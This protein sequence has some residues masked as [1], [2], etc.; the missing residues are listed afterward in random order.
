[1]I[2]RKVFSERVFRVRNVFAMNCS[3]TPTPRCSAA[4][5]L[6]TINR[7]SS[8]TF[9]RFP[10]S[11]PSAFDQILSD[12]LTVSRLYARFCPTP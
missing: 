11:F 8:L 12:S 2:H 9:L 10:C 3:A 7:T 1:M 4:I 5:P 6:L